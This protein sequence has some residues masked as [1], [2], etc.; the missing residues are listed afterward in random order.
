MD[1]SHPAADHLQTGARRPVPPVLDVDAE[2]DAQSVT[3]EGERLMQQI[4]GV[5]LRPAVTHSDER[6]SICEIFSPA[7]GF[8]DEPLCYVYESTIRP[9]VV[10]G[11]VVHYEQDDRLFFSQGSVKIVLYDA[12]R[13]S[14][15]HGLINELFFE[16][17]NRGLLRVP[18]G[19]VHAV[20][21]IGWTD[22]QFINLPTRPYRHEAPDKARLP[23]D[24]EA[25]PYRF[26]PTGL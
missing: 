5:E 15:T 25:I 2:L 7:W 4:A 23:L 3:P 16:A 22:A 26:S 18:A 24:T 8:T 1:S 20:Q 14:P 17:H 12:R 11:W 19:V 10:K 6:G 21:N 13:D 9:G